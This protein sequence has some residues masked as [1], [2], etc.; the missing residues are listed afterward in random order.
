M[1]K[2]QLRIADDFSE[3]ERQI[4]SAGAYVRP[5]DDL[6][7]ATLEAAK[8][9]HWQ[10]YWNKKMS[11]TAAAVLLMA[12]LDLPGRLESIRTSP[13]DN[14]QRM[15][16]EFRDQHQALERSVTPGLNSVWALYEAFFD[17]RHKQAQVIN[18]SL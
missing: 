18:E 10:R 17:L 8:K 11:L 6:R 5:S 3:L 14:A 16:Q 4:R 13:I 7:P 1:A 15:N 9:S 12:V 2:E